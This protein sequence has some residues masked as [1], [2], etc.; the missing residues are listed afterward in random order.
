MI[1]FLEGIRTL[2]TSGALRGTQGTAEMPSLALNLTHAVTTYSKQGE[3]ETPFWKGQ[4]C[5]PLTTGQRDLPILP[6]P[7]RAPGTAALPPSWGES[8]G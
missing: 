1:Y 5:L 2:N 7:I 6:G 3:K 8:L 4:G